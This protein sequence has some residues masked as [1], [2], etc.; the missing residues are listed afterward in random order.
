[1]KIIAYALAYNERR[2][3]PW[4]HR[5][6]KHQGIELFVL[7]NLSTDGT[8]EYLEEHGI[9]HRMV[10]TGGAFDLRPLLAA[11]QDQI[12]KDKPDWFIYASV[13]MFFVAAGMSIARLIFHAAEQGYNMIR[14]PQFTFYHTRVPDYVAPKYAKNP[15]LEN[16]H[17]RYNNLYTF[18][19]E[20]HPDMTLSPDRIN[21]PDAQVL[22][23]QNT[24]ILEMNAGKSIE[25]RM[26]NLKR[27]EKA[28]DKGLKKNLGYHYRILA[29][30]AFIFPEKEQTDI[31]T[32]DGLYALFKKLQRLE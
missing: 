8:T 4:F 18:I 26:E 27:R 3:M 1:M 11:M 25:E 22:Q 24:V 6:M 12:H 32:Q 31:R 17:Y 14:T 30:R 21:R 29:E 7:D 19:S 23:P 10:D 15:F 5:W 16:F 20:Y 2:L 28:W 13:D 9:R